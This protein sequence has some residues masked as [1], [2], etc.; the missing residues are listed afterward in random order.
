MEAVQQALGPGDEAAAAR[1]ELFYVDATHR[2]AELP[3]VVSV[4]VIDT[5]PFAKG[6]FDLASQRCLFDSR[7]RELVARGV[8]FRSVST[9]AFRLLGIPLLAG[10]T[11]LPGDIPPRDAWKHKWYDYPLWFNVPEPQ[12][13][14]IVNATLA[15]RL[16]PNRNPIGQMLYQPSPMRVIG[17]VGDVH[18]S[19]N[20]LDVLPTVYRPFVSSSPLVLAFSY[21]VKLRPGTPLAPFAAAVKRSLSP[22]LP[23]TTPP[24]PVL[25]L[26]EPVGNLRLALA[27]LSCFSLLG[28][29]VAGLGVYATATLMAAARTREMG[30]RLALGAPAQQIGRLVLWR[31]VRLALLAL[32]VGALGAWALGLNLSH[33]LFQVGATDPASY[34]T[35][36]AILLAIA[37]ATGLWPALRAAN[38]DPSAALRYDG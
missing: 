35:S 11:F 30:I 6:A 26:E 9:D 21:V 7:D 29:V 23:G 18:E 31:S 16:W 22:L 33:W 34:L 17:V 24:T 32:P 14:A 3:G 37:L 20:R 25:P 13:V 19:R 4:A 8:L 28:T 1:H 2:L 5:P 38:V 10:R 12:S 15:H 36:A 27:L